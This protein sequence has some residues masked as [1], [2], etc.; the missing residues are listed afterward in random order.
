M[1]EEKALEQHEIGR[2]N[3]ALEK[4]RLNLRKKELE[5][6]VDIRWRNLYRELSN[7]R[8][9][10]DQSQ[11]EVLT[12]QLQRLESNGLRPPEAYFQQLKKFADSS[13]ILE[14]EFAKTMDEIASLEKQMSRYELELKTAGGS[15]ERLELAE[16]VR[17]FPANQLSFFEQLGVYLSRWWEFLSDEP[18]E[19]NSEG[20]VFPAI[21]G[22]MAMTLLMSLAVVP[23]GV[24]AA[25]YLR[26]NAKAGF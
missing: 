23:F 22:T 18:R 21:F 4:E 16:V 15:V 7:A 25:L 1:E 12:T 17:I 14:A 2:I 5:Y 8:K 9:A 13:L 11:V 20:G 24:L 10:G 26:E 6:G 3:Y 19:A